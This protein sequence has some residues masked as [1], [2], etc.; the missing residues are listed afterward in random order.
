MSTKQD[1]INSIINEKR[2]KLHLFN[3]SKREIWTIVGKEKEHWLEPEMQFC[4]CS[5]FYFG[6][7]KSKKPCYHIDSVKIA[8]EKKQYEIIE[9]SDDEFEN[10][11]LSIVNDL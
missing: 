9:F 4:S 10:F 1:R 6:M 8:Q 11:M 7:I 5:G 2:V 3:P